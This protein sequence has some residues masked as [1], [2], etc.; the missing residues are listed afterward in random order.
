MTEPHARHIR[1]EP[2]LQTDPEPSREPCRN[3]PRRANR[4]FRRIFPVQPQR[5][6]RRPE[7]VFRPV[8]PI[9]DPF[10]TK[11]DPFPTIWTISDRS[12]VSVLPNST[13]KGDI[14]IQGAK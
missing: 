14:V 11:S 9:S 6:A 4:I 5:T 8:Q 1:A 7:S 2:S 10:S 12:I 13:P 3:K